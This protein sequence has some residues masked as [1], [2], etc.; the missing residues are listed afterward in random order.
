[1]N[2]KGQALMYG[3]GAAFIAFV[4]LTQMIAPFKETIEDVRDTDKLNCT[5]TNLGTGSRATC[6]LVDWAMPYYL[7]AGF[8]VAI[9]YITFRKL[10]QK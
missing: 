4:F 6:I 2:K 3:L 10:Q 7:F 9:G 5:S 8:A 1:M